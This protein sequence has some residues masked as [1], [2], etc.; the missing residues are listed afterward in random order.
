MVS[1]QPG[2][3]KLGPFSE[4]KEVIVG[5]YH[6]F[7]KDLEEAISLAK[8]NPEFSFTSTAKIEVRPLKTVEK[9]TGF[10]YPAD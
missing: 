5:Y 9:T 6:L 1:G 7:A 10:E 4:D 8:G 2:A 3:F